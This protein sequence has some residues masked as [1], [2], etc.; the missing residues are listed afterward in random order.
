MAR[1]FRIT[2]SICF[3]PSPR[4]VGDAKHQAIQK[5]SQKCRRERVRSFPRQPHSHHPMGPGAI[6]H[7]FLS[8]HPWFDCP[9][10]SPQVVS[11]HQ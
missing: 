4:G 10:L 8:T 9:W 3:Y 5:C 7:A 2:Q 1:G 6:S 11:P